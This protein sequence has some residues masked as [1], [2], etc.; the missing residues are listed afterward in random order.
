MKKFSHIIKDALTLSLNS[1]QA[2]QLAREMDGKFSLSRLTGF[3]ERIAIP[4]HAAA[5]AIM[6]YFPTEEEQIEFL[7]W[8]IHY[9]GKFLYDRSFHFHNIKDT[10]H[11]L[12]LHK[13]IYDA[14]TRHFFRDSFHLEKLNF[15]DAI[16]A[17]DIRDSARAREYLALLK[18]RKEEA[19]TRDVEWSV[20]MR[21]YSM[22][23]D[24][25]SLIHEVVDMLLR[26]VQ[27]QAQLSDVFVAVKELVINASKANYK[28]VFERQTESAYGITARNN[29]P[30]FLEMFRKEIED[31]GQENLAR[32]AEGEDRFFDIIFK[33]SRFSVSF[34][35][36]NYAKIAPPEKKQLMKMLDYKLAEDVTLV[37]EEDPLK[38]GGGMGIKLVRRVL[39]GLTTDPQPLKLVFYPESTKIGF[40]LPRVD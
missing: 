6:K 19:V 9:D 39:A 40:F 25:G 13:W 35:T 31:N 10:I 4:N 12:A 38:E 16:Q 30:A 36:Q 8:M 26:C 3:G 2:N 37:D 14:D 23:Q 34:W 5:E 17:M 28:Q 7:Q 21:L 32:L 27:R 1:D 20:T 15:L 18:E 33:N 11:Q 29:Y 24:S 22:N